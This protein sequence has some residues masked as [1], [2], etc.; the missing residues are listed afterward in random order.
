MATCRPEMWS[1]DKALM[2]ISHC[3]C[4]VVWCGA[5]VWCS[6][7]DDLE[8]K[9]DDV[10]LLVENVDSV[11]DMTYEEA[12]QKGMA[13]HLC[14]T[15]RIVRPLRSKHCSSCDRCVSRFDHHCPWVNNCVGEKN[16]RAFMCFLLLVTTVLIY[17]VL[18]TCVYLFHNG[19]ASEY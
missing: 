17:H 12:L 15:C 7:V 11:M 8:N 10:T 16:H 3:A 14:V 13:D 2:L 6:N 1:R 19:V 5:V 4:S 18:V 9:N